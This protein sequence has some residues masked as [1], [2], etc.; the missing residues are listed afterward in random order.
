MNIN[1]HKPHDDCPFTRDEIDEFKA[2][3][4]AV[5]TGNIC[6]NPA[7]ISWVDGYQRWQV[8]NLQEPMQP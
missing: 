1:R 2:M 3:L 6:M 7:P 5:N 8:R 4:Y